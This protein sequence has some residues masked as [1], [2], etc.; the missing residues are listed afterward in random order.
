MTINY[1]TREGHNKINQQIKQ[2]KSVDLASAIV[3]LARARESGRLDENEEFHQAQAL[4]EQIEARIGELSNELSKTT[5][6]TGNIST[7]VV[8]FGSC[9]TVIGP[10]GKR[11]LTLVGELETDASRGRVSTKSPIGSAL[12]DH[13]E[14]DVVDVESPAG[15]VTY[16]IVKITV[17]SI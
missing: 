9:V 4:C 14:G 6:F 17:G 8:G 12:V 3:D 5:I 15:W 10:Q 7:D 2:L 1:I 16:E 13:V 11:F